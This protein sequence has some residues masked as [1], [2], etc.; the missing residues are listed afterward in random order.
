MPAPSPKA[1]A[2]PT[3][4]PLNGASKVFSQFFS[5]LEHAGLRSIPTLHKK[6]D[7]YKH[8]VLLQ[9]KLSHFYIARGYLKSIEKV[10]EKIV[11]LDIFEVIE[12]LQN[13]IDYLLSKRTDIQ[14]KYPV[15]ADAHIADI[16][17]SFN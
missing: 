7:P 11:G 16:S 3:L 5:A 17:G 14:K 4:L 8:E 6:L 2:I 9:E 15:M 13:R 12:T 10:K 1:V